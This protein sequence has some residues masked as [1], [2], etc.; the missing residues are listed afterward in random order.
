MHRRAFVGGLALIT[1]AAPRAAPAQPTRKVYRIGILALPET[2]D[3]VG[4]NPGPL[5]IAR[6]C[7][8]CASW[9]TCME[10]IS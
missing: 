10:R 1:L 7:A 8:D 9:A 6:S 2:S 3:M 4:P 5:S